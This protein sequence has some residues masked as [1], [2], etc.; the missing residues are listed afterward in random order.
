[1][2]RGKEGIAWVPSRPLHPFLGLGMILR[3]APGVVN[4]TTCGLG[5]VQCCCCCF[6]D[7]QGIPLETMF[8]LN[9]EGKCIENLSVLMNEDGCEWRLEATTTPNILYLFSQG[10]FTFIGEKS[11]F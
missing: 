6:S 3:L 7:A 5:F 9:E 2:Q 10:N 11:K 8:F 4:H 1:L